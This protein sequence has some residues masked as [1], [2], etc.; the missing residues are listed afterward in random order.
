MLIWLSMQ[1]IPPAL[2]SMLYVPGLL[3]ESL[4]RAH[5]GLYA[6]G[7][8]P[9]R[10][11]PGP[12]LSVGNITMGGSGKTPLVLYIAHVL[13]Q[14][15]FQPAILTRG[16]KRA[17]GQETRILAP[18]EEVS[19]AA[20]VLGDEPAVMR[21]HFS[22][23]WM[24]ISKNRFRAGSIISQKLRQAVFI[25][26]DG[27]Q[28]RKLYRDL[29]IVILDRS[30][31]LQ[32]N[33]V[34]PQG[35]LREPLSGLHRCHAIVLNGTRD[36]DDGGASTEEIARYHPKASIFYCSQTIE[37]LVPLAPWNVMDFSA[38]APRPLS[39]Y[40]IAAIGNPRRFEQDVRRLGIDVRGAKYFPD[41]YW[42]TPGDW[43]AC[44]E[45]ARSKHAEA[46]LTTEKD[47]V[48]ISQPPDFPVMVSLQST[49]MSDALAFEAMLLRYVEEP[50]GG[51]QRSGMN[52]EKS[53]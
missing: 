50:L 45:D 24:G 38:E 18:G 34:F 51:R 20:R 48:K 39:A 49:C 25:L 32:S 7:V 26:D 13:T 11:L 27:F 9:Q 52:A 53:G 16:Y 5:N 35:T 40:L 29:D 12:V 41:H 17:Q 10:H 3:Y 22:S 19:S 31:A 42:P 43:R 21:R 1:R 37:S 23:A 6:A 47:A 4:V 33:R 30:Q 36:E 14:R 44:A 28:H 15:G 2:A 46:I 8:L